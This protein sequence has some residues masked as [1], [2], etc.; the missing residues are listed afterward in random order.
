MNSEEK[1][2]DV[3]AIIPEDK[4][5]LATRS[6]ALISRGLRDLT[7]SLDS[8]LVEMGKALQLGRFMEEVIGEMIEKAH[9]VFRSETYYL[10]LMDSEKGE[11]YGSPLIGP[12]FA[13]QDFSSTYV[14][15]G[16]G[17]GLAGWVARTG[18]LA[19]VP[20]TSQDSRFFAEVDEMGTTKAR[21]IVAAPVRRNDRCLGVIELINCVGPEGFSKRKLAL[22][23]ALTD[24]AAI[25]IENSRYV[26]AIHELTITDDN[27]S[28]ENA[29]ALHWRLDM[30]ISR[31]LSGKGEFSLIL[32]DLELHLAET[33][34]SQWKDFREVPVGAWE[35]CLKQ[36]GQ[37]LKAS[38][39]LVDTA[40]RYTDTR[41]AILLPGLAEHPGKT[42]EKACRV[43]CDLSKQFAKAEWLWYAGRAVK[44]PAC[45]GVVSFPKDA[46][47][48]DELLRLAEE[49][50]SLVRRTG[51]GGV[52]AA[53]MGV[54][55]LENSGD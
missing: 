3:N 8:I 19:I 48:K 29:R 51:R 47:T 25:A 52:A 10:F 14:K 37:A 41:F 39:G 35:S 13:G 36:V 42:K 6:P 16:E 31:S 30:E 32:I 9:E 11:L 21:S 27:T 46:T 15:V 5:G 17:G 1:N 45:I 40:Y 43:S 12:L 28:L 50:M 26:R 23:E 33:G 54:L 4:Q 22:L 44:L 2:V 18:Q 7:G 53:N 38:C 24:F 20:D 34:Q 49:T 55:Q